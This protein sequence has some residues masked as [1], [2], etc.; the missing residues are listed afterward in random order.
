MTKDIQAML[1]RVLTTLMRWRAHAV[2]RRALN[3]LDDHILRDIGLTRSQALSEAA[4]PFWRGRQETPE[5]ERVDLPSF[6]DAAPK[7]V[8]LLR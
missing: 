1:A 2:E 7:R 6:G 8:R 4:R 5:S 3:E